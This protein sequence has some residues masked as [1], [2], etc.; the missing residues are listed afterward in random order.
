MDLVHISSAK[1]SDVLKKNQ[2]FGIPWL[3]EIVENMSSD[4]SHTNQ[5]LR[6]T[7]SSQKRRKRKPE[8][9]MIIDRIYDQSETEEKI[10]DEKEISRPSE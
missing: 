8:A 4:F 10:N 2:L 5:R 1:N 3:K 6:T 9:D 7:L